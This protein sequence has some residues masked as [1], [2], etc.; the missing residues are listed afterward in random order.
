MIHPGQVEAA[1]TAFS[2]TAED[3]ATARRIVEAFALPQNRG[4]GAIALDGVMVERLHLE[5]AER[6]LQLEGRFAT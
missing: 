4:L 6:L 5:S 1:N 3:F 2:P